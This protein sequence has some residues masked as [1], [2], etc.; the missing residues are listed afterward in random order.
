[1]PLFALHKGAHRRGAFRDFHPFHPT[2]SSWAFKPVFTEAFKPVSGSMWHHLVTTWLPLGATCI[3][4]VNYLNQY[5]ATILPSGARMTLLCGR[6]GPRHCWR[7]RRALPALSL[8]SSWGVA[9]C[10]WYL[11]H[12]TLYLVPFNLSFNQLGLPWALLWTSKIDRTDRSGGSW[13]RLARARRGEWNWIGG[14]LGGE[15]GGWGCTG[16]KTPVEM[17]LLPWSKSPPRRRWTPPAA[18]ASAGRC[19]GR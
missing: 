15:V 13:C 2:H 17:D 18:G 12:S 3:S 11:A 4:D 9:P 10:T 1:M 19:W 7:N 5:L 14:G 6:P 8:S 16:E